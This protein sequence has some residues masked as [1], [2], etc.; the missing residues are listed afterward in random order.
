MLKIDAK[1]T[2][3][4]VCCYTKNIAIMIFILHK[5]RGGGG[6]EILTACFTLREAMQGGVFGVM[7][8]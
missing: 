3:Q 8:K 5:Y 2:V 7:Y 1:T 4:L 6:G